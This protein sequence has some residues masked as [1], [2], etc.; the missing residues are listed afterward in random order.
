MIRWA[1]QKLQNNA[2]LILITA[3]VVSNTKIFCQPVASFSANPT[4][5]CVPLTVNFQ[6]NSVGTDSY[7]WDFGNGNTS[8]LQNPATVYLAPGFY[9]VSLV[10]INSLTG[11]RDT[12]I[13]TNY[14]HTIPAPNTNFTAT[15][16]SGCEN[17]NTIFFTNTSAGAVSYI[18]DFG[19]GTS[20]TLQNPV[21]SYSAPGNYTVKLIATN[22]FNCSE[23]ETKTNYITIH[24]KPN[25][26]LTSAFSS[27]CDSTDVFSFSG[28]GTGVTNWQWNFGDGS[29]SS[30]QN[31]AHV[32]NSTG[33]FNVTMIATNNFGCSDTVVQNNYINIGT[34]LVP[35]FSVTNATGCDSL[36]TNFTPLVQNATS[37]L[38]DFG[39]GSTSTQQNPAHFY[40]ATGNYTITLT[41]TTASG[42]NG[43]ATYTNAIVVDP[44][45]TA[46]FTVVQLSPCDDFTFQFTNTSTGAATYLWE[47]GDGSTSTSQN[48]VHTYSGGN[49]MDVTLHVFS[50][51][52]CETVV[53]VIDA[54]IILDRH[55]TFMGDP[56]TGCAPLTVSFT[57][58]NYPNANSW[59]W[60]FGDGGTSTLQN[61]THTYNATGNYNVKLV[62]GTTQGCTDSLTK[63][64]HIRVV[65]GQVNYIV[66][67]TIIGCAPFAVSFANPLPGCNY[68]LWNFGNGDTSNNQNPVY[69]YT[70]PGTYVVTFYGSMAGGCSQ[71][72]DPF[73]IIT[74]FEF[75]PLPIDIIFASNCKPF[76]FQFSNP[77]PDVVSYVW[78]FGDG[79][80]NDT[81]MSPSHTFVQAGTYTVSVTLT[82][83]NGCVKTVST[84][85]TVG[86]P[87]PIQVSNLANCSGSP[88]Q[89]NI[90]NAAAFTSYIWNFGDGSPTSNIQNPAHSYS[91]PGNYLASLIVNDTGG[92]IDTFYSDTLHIYTLS[93]GFISDTTAGCNN[94][95]VHFINTSSG[96]TSYLWDFGDSTTASNTNPAHYYSSPGTYTVTLTASNPGCTQTF[97]QVNYITVHFSKADF[98]FT[99]N[100]NCF[101]ITATFTDLSNNATIWLWDFGDGN[102]SIQQNP[103]HVF[104][105]QPT[106]P[107][108]L[109]IID[110]N[111]C[112]DSKIRN[113]IS[114]IPINAH[115]ADTLGCKPHSTA[116]TD[117]TNNATS[118]LWDF[119]DGTTSTL[120]NPTHIYAD[121]GVYTIQFTVTLSTGCTSTVTLPNQVYVQVPFADFSSLINTACAPALIQF[122]DLSI[123]AASWLWDFGDGSS[124]PSQNPSHIYNMPGNYT[125]TLQVWDSS[126]CTAQITK[127]DFVQVPGTYAYFSLSPAISCLN[128]FVQFADSSINA[129]SWAWNFGDGYTSTM[130]N[131]SHTYQDTGSFIVS[132]I[133]ADSLGCSSYYTFPDPVVV[134]PAPVIDTA[135]AITSQ[136]CSAFTT[137]FNHTSSGYS[138]I[139]WH[140]GDGDTSNTDAPFHTYINWGIY[141]VMLIATNQFGCVDTFNL[142]TPVESFQNPIAQFTPSVATGCSPLP[143][144]MNNQSNQ[145]QNSGYIWNFGN[146]N[147]SFLQNPTEI[148]SNGGTYFISLVVTNDNGCSD[149]VTKSI[150]VNTSPDALASTNDTMGCRPYSATFIN[151]S[152]N[153]STHLWVFGDGSTSPLTNPVHI[154][155]NSGIYYP[156][157]ITNTSNGCTDTFFFAR[158]VT[159]LQD[160]VA[161]FTTSTPSGCAGSSITLNDASVNLSNPGYNWTIGSITSTQQNP[162]VTLSTPGFYTVSLTVTNDNGCID[163]ITK[164][165]FIE[166]FST[167]PPALT[168]LL[169]VSVMNNSSV[170]V[171]WLPGADLYL[172]EYKLYRLNTF[173]SNYDLIYTLPDSNITNPNVNL[174]YTDNGLNTLQNVYTYKVQTINLCGYAL[175][176][177]QSLAHTT[178]NVSAQTAGQAINVNWTAYSGCS[179]SNYEIHRTE[180]S[181]GLVQFVG[182]VPGNTLVFQDTT[183]NCPFEYSYRITARD[184]CGNTYTSLSDTAIA[185]PLNMLVNQQS[186]IVR[187]TVIFNESIL[188]E[189]SVPIIQPDR[190]TKYNILRSTDK[191]NYSLIASVPATQQSYIDDNVDVQEQNYFYRVDVVN[192]C[193]LSG[194]LSNNSS[195]VLL[196]SDWINEKAKI[197]WTQYDNWDT[198]VDQ[199]IIE[200]KDLS[201]Q[202]IQIKV[203]DG[204]ILE[205]E[206][207]E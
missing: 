45:P 49:T 77:T 82:H 102:I 15:P 153:A 99:Q 38:W 117:S 5:G 176:L 28:S 53:T 30:Q 90:S 42:C 105:N 179:V 41:V 160:P 204:N 154:Y 130:Q 207:D 138:Y 185:T 150:Q 56:R 14:I 206:L 62:V 103:V 84:T 164:N 139:T 135:F 98:S 172:K 188:T 39:D 158:P 125:I 109:T 96:A 54:V 186:D 75:L 137:S 201:G 194:V 32:Y 174:I 92:C 129:T 195:S 10:A 165:N 126:G 24:S 19:D 162:S 37:W 55:V 33:S 94:L 4:V 36:T 196:K 43:T 74:V 118:W 127:I 88:V 144:T 136:G 91:A 146:G 111:G 203:V 2:V 95:T 70:V 17:N 112:S 202:W 192:D 93:T 58:S 64:S 167:Q 193:N 168:P 68:F 171:T 65:A 113:N 161:D 22:G 119:G 182:N 101:P 13:A 107:V 198:D 7:Y 166:I 34:S 120:Q 134:Y 128:T 76:N 189:W 142:T 110:I 50:P 108:T 44:T 11:Q 183:L 61:P 100:G 178:I 181:S 152:V 148:F 20:S 205:I 8:T 85:L 156:Y 143:V 57:P 81:T 114:G 140:F 170:N 27:S 52:G 72:I 97:S 89:F 86:H 163:S 157:L 197:W 199:Y 124:S 133:T 9:T 177:S 71:Y 60:T 31:P 116:F 69:T 47:F 83:I 145:L 6:D 67:D 122:N 48:P 78:D 46:S 131:P 155:N 169:S 123:N 175:P 16:A 26:S 29:V 51:N 40:S 191:L 12:F 25:A 18:W 73:A 147:V 87:N 21:H 121:T 79:S 63:V 151:Q 35:N 1:F 190:V 115:I 180:L 184:L 200:K 159:V 59:L 149:S 23:I 187:S 80:P 104:T 66:P 3:F 106:G 173:T 132:L 141:Q